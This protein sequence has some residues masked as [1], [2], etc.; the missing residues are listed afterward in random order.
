[1]TRLPLLLLIG[2]L[3]VGGLTGC[4]GGDDDGKQGDRRVGALSPTDKTTVRTLSLA[5]VHEADAW[6]YARPLAGVTHGRKTPTPP[7]VDCTSAPA[8]GRT[9]SWGYLQNACPVANP[10]C[11][12][13]VSVVAWP[14]PGERVVWTGCTSSTSPVACTVEL[15]DSTSVTAKF[16]K[17]T[18]RKLSLTVINQANASGSVEQVNVMD[19][20]RGGG[21]PGVVCGSLAAPGRTC[22]WEYLQSI[23]AGDKTSCPVTVDLFIN[24]PAASAVVWTGCSSVTSTSRLCRVELPSDKNVK[25]TLIAS[26]STV[27]KLSLTVVGPTNSGAVHQSEVWYG[28]RSEPAPVTQCAWAP[29]PGRTCTWEYLQGDPGDICVDQVPDCT[30]SARLVANPSPGFRVVW[31]GCSFVLASGQPGGAPHGA[32]VVTLPGE[33]SAKA[34]FEVD[35]KG[36]SG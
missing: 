10:D 19:G 18:P 14:R 27:R 5:V 31:S 32:C 15:S 8:P 25:A 11:V 16:V 24:D 22:T 36:G 6:G 30:V 12:V 13:T 1:M 26:K 9:C 20:A 34:T 3:A 33:K 23:C 2:A 17:A 28:S 21:T 29:A 4:M 7:L 35:P